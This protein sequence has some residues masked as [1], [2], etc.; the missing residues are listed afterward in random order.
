MRRQG[1]WLQ[2]LAQDEH[3]GRLKRFTCFYSNCDNIVFPASTA[4]LPGADNRLVTGEA[5]VDMAF[6]PS[7][8]G[9]SLAMLNSAN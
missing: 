2:Q 4:M 3:E 1:Q 8:M 6:N 9:Q 7:V 5:H